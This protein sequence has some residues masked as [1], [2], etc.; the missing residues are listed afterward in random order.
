[1]VPYG[2][3]IEILHHLF[4]KNGNDDVDDNMKY[5]DDDDDDDD[6][7]KHANSLSSATPAPYGNAQRKSHLLVIDWLNIMYYIIFI[8]RLAKYSWWGHKA[9]P[10]TNKN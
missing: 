5:A 7:N 2:I 3:N 9:F 1:M 6:D 10:A 4:V 8:Y